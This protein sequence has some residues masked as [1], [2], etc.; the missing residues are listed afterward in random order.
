MF[1]SDMICISVFHQ[2]I[3]EEVINGIPCEKWRLVDTIGEK[4][5][6]YT[7]WIRYKVCNL[8]IHRY[9]VLDEIVKYI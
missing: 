2:C 7:L 4:A 5:N 8:T 1:Y 3:G 6:K 9:E